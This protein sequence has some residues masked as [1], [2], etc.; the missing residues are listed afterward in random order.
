[1]EWPSTLANDDAVIAAEEISSGLRRVVYGR[2]RR[3][4]FACET[5]AEAA[6]RAV[7]YAKHARASAW[8]ADGR[9]FQLLGTCV[10]A[11]LSAPTITS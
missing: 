5:Y 9:R 6:A 11:S 10:R 7:S 8:Y 1:M 2:S 3:A 4:Q